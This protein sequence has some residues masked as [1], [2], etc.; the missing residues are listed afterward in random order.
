M[1]TQRL[2]NGVDKGEVRNTSWH[3][4]AQVEAN[5]VPVSDDGLVAY[6]RYV[7]Q[8]EEYEGDEEEERG[9]KGPYFAPASCDFDL[10]FA[11]FGDDDRGRG[12]RH[13]SVIR[14]PAAIEKIHDKRCSNR[15][16]P[17]LSTAWSVESERN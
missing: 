17:Q 15:R 13:S 14:L 16:G 9:C 12:S 5:K 6:T 2:S 1:E 8:D 10:L 7:D 4:I 3:N 11:Q